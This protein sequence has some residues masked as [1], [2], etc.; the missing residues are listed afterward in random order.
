MGDI[1]AK[2]AASIYDK[3][4]NYTY[5]YLRFSKTPT[6]VEHTDHPF[7]ALTMEQ[8]YTFYMIV[9]FYFVIYES[10]YIERHIHNMK[11]GVLL[12]SHGES[13]DTKCRLS[14]HW[15]S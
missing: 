15:L 11:N 9:K 13:Y 7:T 14:H 10:I 6:V 5:Y 12:R 3:Y 8:L 1:S 4:Q 2:A